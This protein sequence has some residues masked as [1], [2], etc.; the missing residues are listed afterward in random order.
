[1][2]VAFKSVCIYM[3]SLYFKGFF[4]CAYVIIENEGSHMGNIGGNKNKWLKNNSRFVQLCN[5]ICML[6]FCMLKFNMQIF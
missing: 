5:N 3:V 4:I 2:I 1:M 6:N